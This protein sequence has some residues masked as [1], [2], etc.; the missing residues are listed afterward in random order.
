MALPEE[1]RARHGVDSGQTRVAAT[2]NL[3][4]FIEERQKAGAENATINRELAIVR[5]AFALAMREDPPLVRKL[6]YIPQLEEDN[7]RQGFLEHEGYEQL[8]G[9]YRKG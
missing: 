8:L 1:Y 4:T 3:R 7:V 2:E 9:N 6:P 5:R